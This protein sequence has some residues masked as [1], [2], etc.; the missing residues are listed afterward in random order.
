MVEWSNLPKYSNF[1]LYS[2]WTSSKKNKCDEVLKM[3]MVVYRK[4]YLIRYVPFKSQIEKKIAFY[5]LL[6]DDPGSNDKNQ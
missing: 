5:A 4:K 6:L 1:F 2:Y 3:T